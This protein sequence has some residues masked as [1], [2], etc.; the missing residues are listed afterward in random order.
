M[1]ESRYMK[2]CYRFGLKFFTHVLLVTGLWVFLCGTQA[3]AQIAVQ[4]WVQRYNG[5]G[6][7]GDQPVAIAVDGSNNVVVT[8][9]SYS[10]SSSN[11]WAT[12]KYSSA[13]VPLWT[14]R[15][16][17]PGS[18]PEDKPTAMAVDGNGDVIVTGWMGTTGGG[19]YATMKYSG[20]GVPLWTNYYISPWGWSDWATAIAVD[21]CGNVFVTGNSGG[22]NFYL[23]YRYDYATIKYS[24]AGVPLWT[25]RY[26][27][28]AN[29]ED[30]ATAVGVDGSGNVFVTGY[31][32]TTNFPTRYECVT[33]KYAGAGEPV[34]TNRFLTSEG[35]K[36][37][38][39][40]GHGNVFVKGSTSAITGYSG[41]GF[42]LWTNRYTGQANA[43]AVDG[44]GNVLVT[45]YSDSVSNLS[46]FATIKYSAAGVPLWTNRHNGPSNGD[47]KAYAIAV[48]SGGN[49]I[50]TGYSRGIGS[51]ND[52]TTIKYSGAGVP[53]WTNRY[54]GLGNSDDRATALAVDY[55]GNVYVTGYSIGSGTGYDY[56]TI[57]YSNAGPLLSITRTMTNTVAVSWPS[58]AMDFTLQQNTN[59]AATNWTPVVTIPA[60]DGTN[61][62]AI[63]DTPEGSRFYRLAH[64]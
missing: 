10:S 33:I 50:V 52:F 21:H 28:P 7:R 51:S 34:W 15:Y 35:H 19:R 25:N 39:V 30:R 23:H 46:D 45:G 32:A 60:D 20:A 9:Y 61:K 43:L 31:S 13:G 63:V 44:E 26:N 27:G 38:A 42:P 17:G 40:D 14:N 18:I 37:L 62:T 16:A 3:R 22:E 48:D 5:P 64:P 54:N 49:V 36:G 8:G 41:A 58:S 59:A 57:K 1:K 55:R 29:G 12:I 24:S 53:L 6:N 11:D 56:V 47:D 2:M 4:E